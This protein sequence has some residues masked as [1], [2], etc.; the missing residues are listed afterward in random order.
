MFFPILSSVVFTNTNIFN[1][2]NTLNVIYINFQYFH[3]L[4]TYKFLEFSLTLSKNLFSCSVQASYVSLLPSQTLISLFSHAHDYILQLSLDYACTHHH[5]LA[6]IISNVLPF[7]PPLISI[8]T[9]NG[10]AFM[11]THSCRPSIWNSRSPLYC[12]L[13]CCTCNFLI[14]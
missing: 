11:C 4:F 12:W 8:T 3:F 7:C 9:I 6:L 10:G 5:H 1:Y 13:R 14:W 2:F